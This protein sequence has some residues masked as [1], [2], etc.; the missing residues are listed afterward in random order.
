[1]NT[2]TKNERQA[3]NSKREGRFKKMIRQEG[4]LYLM[5]LP[6]VA[7]IFVFC[8]I[9]MYGVLMAFEN[10]IPARGILGSEWVWFK[11]FRSF[12]RDPFC[13]R[14]IRNTVLLGVYSLVFSFP[15]PIILALL[16]NEL[17]QNFFKRAI[18]TISYMPYFI[19]TVIVVGL[20]KEIFSLSGIANEL[21]QMLGGSAVSFMERPEWFRTMY[22]GSGVWQNIGFSSILYLATISGINPEL[23]E[24]AILDG[25]SRIKQMIY[26]TIPCIAPTIQI[27]FIFAVGG[28][29][30]N[31][32]Q[33]ILLMYSEMTY[34]TAD[35]ISTYVY[36]RGLI[37]GQFSYS[38]AVG[39]LTSVF[40]FALIWITNTVNRK[41]GAE[42]FF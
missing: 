18:Q 4:A 27:M 25:A 17:K 34:E 15:A 28:I 12:F 14:T 10:Y 38:S 41:V 2:S 20:M 13:W 6:A 19:S 39:L 23:Y 36:R 3:N 33:K 40:S 22:I 5:V 9:P 21:V 42:S 30:G 1:M 35:V 31:D 32:F 11:H 8:Y 24:S 16:I 37:G 29:L 26:I 7:L